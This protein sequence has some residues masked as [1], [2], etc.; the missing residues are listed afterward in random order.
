MIDKSNKSKMNVLGTMLAVLTCGAIVQGCAPMIV[1]GVMAGASVVA[2]RRPPG[3]QLDDERIE[4]SALLEAKRAHGDGT[5]LNI[6][7]YH[8][9]VLLSGEVFNEDQKKAIEELVRANR[10]VKTIYNELGVLPVA[11]LA[12]VSADSA[13]TARVKANLV[14]TKGVSANNVKVITER[15]IV[16]LMGILSREEAGLAS[17]AA[18]L[19][20]GVEKVVRLFEY[21]E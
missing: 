5:H 8:Y 14:N 1:G 4:N 11:S 13:L 9:N 6:T 7:S 19:T 16:F 12:S 17:E 15:R 21:R 18:R 10:L 2:D 3:A 20:N